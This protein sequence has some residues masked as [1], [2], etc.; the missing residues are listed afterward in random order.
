[1]CSDF[2]SSDQGPDRPAGVDSEDQQPL[3]VFECGAQTSVGLQSPE[4]CSRV[5]DHAVSQVDLSRGPNGIDQSDAPFS[6]AGPV[7][8]VCERVGPRS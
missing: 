6:E 7:K 5:S 3:T 8:Q 2:L 1:M 4:L